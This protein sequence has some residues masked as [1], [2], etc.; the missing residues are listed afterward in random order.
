MT[1]SDH[2]L[3]RAAEP[4]GDPHAPLDDGPYWQSVALRELGDTAAARLR[5]EQMLRVAREQPTEEARIPYFATSLPTMLLFDDDL[6]ARA[7]REARYLRGAGAAEPSA[8]QRGQDT[9]RFTSGRGARPT[10]GG[11]PLD[12]AGVERGLIIDP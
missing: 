3:A 9:L 8:T 7:R 4:Q 5:A 1:A 6:R 12:R 10:G 11:A 2:W